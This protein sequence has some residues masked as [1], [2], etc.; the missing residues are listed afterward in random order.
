MRMVLVDGSDSLGSRIQ[1][2]PKVSGGAIQRSYR[3]PSSL[4][5][6]ILLILGSTSCPQRLRCV[7]F[8]NFPHEVTAGN[9]VR[10][11]EAVAF[12]AGLDQTGGRSKSSSPTVIEIVEAPHWK[13]NLD[14]GMKQSLPRNR[15]LHWGPMIALSITFYIGCVSSYFAVMWWPLTT[16][17]GYLHLIL[18]FFWNYSTMVNLARASFIGAGHVPLG[19]TPD[20]EVPNEKDSFDSLLQWC[21]PCAGYKV[22]RSHHCSNCGRCCMKMDHHCPW[23]NNCVGHRNHAFFV[24]FLLSAVIGC[25]HAVV[26]LI[27]SFYHAIN[28]NYYYR[29]GDGTEPEVIL[30]FWSLIAMI[31]GSAFAFG[32]VVG[33][34]GLLYIQLKYIKNNKTGIEEYIEQKAASYRLEEECDWEKFVYPY[35]LGWKRN[36]REVLFSWSGE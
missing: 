9:S 8:S 6:V 16:I 12:G 3:I 32:V 26:I 34:G 23:I 7:L 2:A 20:S 31:I 14:V 24:R 22:P 25:I 29:F 36:F 10:E 27:A 30:T 5:H 21:E 11:E 4:I 15:L 35:D 33:V 17:G 19:W 18:F 13:P 1:I 28:L